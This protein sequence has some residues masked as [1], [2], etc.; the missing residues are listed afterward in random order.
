MDRFL[1]RHRIA[2]VAGTIG[3]LLLAS[4]LLLRLRLDFD[5]THMQPP[6]APAVRAY[7]E[8][9]RDPQANMEA[10]NVSAS[11]LDAARTLAE[12]L[13]RLPE[14]SEVRTVDVLLPTDQAAKLPLVERAAAALGPVSS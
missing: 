4:P 6:N 14:V 5:P 11:S 3:V 2:V 9:A 12:R 7:H 13:R 1:G 10:I 8:L